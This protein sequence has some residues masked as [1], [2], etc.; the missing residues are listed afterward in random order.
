MML[1]KEMVNR[2]LLWH[3]EQICVKLETDDGEEIV[4]GPDRLEFLDCSVLPETIALYEMLKE[5]EVSWYE[6]VYDSENKSYLV[7]H[8]NK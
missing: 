3:K 6:S 1:F 5:K 8:L 4:Y 7:Y 2:E